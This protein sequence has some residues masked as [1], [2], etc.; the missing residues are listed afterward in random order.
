MDVF[1]Y[2]ITTSVTKVSVNIINLSKG[3]SLPCLNEQSYIVFRLL[4]SYVD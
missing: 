4:K 2:E 1:I 3:L